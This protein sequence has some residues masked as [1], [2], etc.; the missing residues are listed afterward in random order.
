MPFYS[1]HFITRAA[2]IF[3]RAEFIPLQRQITTSNEALIFIPRF[4]FVIEWSPPYVDC[5][6][7]LS[8]STAI[9]P[10]GFRC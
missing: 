1:V 2:T 10:R 3:R 7:D 5:H 4:A 6:L 8:D 9:R